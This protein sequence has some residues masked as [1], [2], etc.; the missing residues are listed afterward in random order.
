MNDQ[1]KPYNQQTA[2]A[3]AQ[4]GQ[5]PQNCTDAY[6]HEKRHLNPLH[7]KMQPKNLWS[8]TRG[9]RLANTAEKN[10]PIAPPIK[11]GAVS[12]KGTEVNLFCSKKEQ[13]QMG[14]IIPTEQ[15]N[16]ISL[17]SLQRKVRSGTRTKP[18]P[19]P[20]IPVTE[21]AANPARIYRVMICNWITSI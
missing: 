2:A 8:H 6:G 19:E 12:R 15:G 21:P 13:K 10:P 17:S 16:T 1:C 3:N 4:A 18:P 20:R 14:S 7:N 9:I 5:Q 11:Y